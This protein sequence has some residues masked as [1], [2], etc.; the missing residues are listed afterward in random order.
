MGKKE[1][2]TFLL[3]LFGY[4]FIFIF[5][6]PFFLLFYFWL[7]TFG[8]CVFVCGFYLLSGRNVA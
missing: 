2:V 3:F 6:F 7:M 8:G 1:L 4:F 5:I